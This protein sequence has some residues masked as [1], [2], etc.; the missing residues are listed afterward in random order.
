MT[1]L[2]AGH[3]YGVRLLRQLS[4]GPLNA[5]QLIAASRHGKL[6]GCGILSDPGSGLLFLLLTPEGV[7]AHDLEPLL[8][9]LSSLWG[10]APRSA[11]W[12]GNMGTTASILN[13]LQSMCLNRSMGTGQRLSANSCRSYFMPDLGITH[14]TSL[15]VRQT[16]FTSGCSASCCVA[17]EKDP[18]HP[19]NVLFSPVALWYT[20]IRML[21]PY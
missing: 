17:V 14:F 10:V 11:S 19:Q 7:G 5:R 13:G 1:L 8:L 18:T 15:G 6:R 3:R 9:L 2:I 16:I 20:S 12:A 21:L 4:A